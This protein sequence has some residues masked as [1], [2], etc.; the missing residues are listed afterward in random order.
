MQLMVLLSQ[1]VLLPFYV[2][3]LGVEAYAW[4]GIYVSLQGLFVMLDLGMSTTINQEMAR[5]SGDEDSKKLHTF[6]RHLRLVI[7]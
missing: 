3:L 2:H 4:I 1:L 5:L 7:G 6:S